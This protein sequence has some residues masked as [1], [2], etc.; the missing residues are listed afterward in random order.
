MDG[1][2]FR[3]ARTRAGRSNVVLNLAVLMWGVAPSF[4]SEPPTQP[5]P[6]PS[7]LVFASKPYQPPT[8]KRVELTGGA[9]LHLAPD[10][11]LPLVELAVALRAG[12]FLEPP[13][14]V[15]LTELGTALLRR[16]GAGDLT[17]EELDEQ[18]DLLGAELDT[19]GGE[20]R[21]G[22]RLSVPSWE[23]E[24]AL[25]LV[26]DVLARP[27]LAEDRLEVLRTNVAESMS[28]R[29][30]DPLDVLLREWGWLLFGDFYASRQ[31][32]S[33]SLEH[34]TREAIGEYHRAWWRPENLVFAV[35][36]DFDPDSIV[37]RLERR[38][39][40]WPDGGE[41]MSIPWP[42]P[43]PGKG[44]AP[45]LYL[46]L[47]ETPQ[48]KI[49]IGHRV[50][51]DL[52]WTARE[53]VVVEVLQE[54]LGGGGAISRL[55]G[56][57]RTS[58]GLVYRTWAH[59][60]PGPEPPGYLRVFLETD[61]P[62]AARAIE[63]AV[64]EIERLRTD[65]VHPR[66]LEVVRRTLLDRIPSSFDTPEKIAGQYS[67]NELLGRPTNYWERRIE[68]LGQVTREEIRDA[69]RKYLRTA[70]LIYL[71]VAP[72]FG[73]EGLASLERAAGHSTN[74]LPARDPSTLEPLP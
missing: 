27:R 58:T 31:I 71:V 33:A 52:G 34:V 68:T 37:A 59:L 41:V 67:E 14:A 49:L 51:T 55:G 28:R 72:D 19:V 54:V 35:S 70:D 5:A 13:G 69:A 46:A 50:D 16:G 63:L 42:P 38:L 73:E 45:G 11:S 24:P 44:A 12:S 32:T 15:G 2:L 7:A 8:A 36:G 23:L 57:L 10:P 64:E 26:F 20:R 4:A 60:E 62:K 39:V 21:S 18:I 74:L 48:T 61:P 29:N 40:A 25:D 66:E 53:R 17:A 30:Q 1:T 22:L 47:S 65:L 43:R 56:R 9:V 3:S 6:H